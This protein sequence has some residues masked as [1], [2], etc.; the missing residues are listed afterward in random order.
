VTVDGV[1]RKA[2]YPVPDGALIEVLLPPPEPSEVEPE[3]IPLAV[4]YEDEALIAIDKPAGMATHPAPGSRR[5]TLVAALLHHWHLDGEW[6]DPQRPGVVH[7]LDKDTTGVIVVAKTPQAMHALARQFAA[8]T[9][10]K[11]Y[12]AIVVGAPRAA[13]GRIDLAIG[14]DPL[15]RKRMRARVGEKRVAVTS[16]EVLERFGA[17]PAVAASVRLRPETGRTHQIRV[18]LASIGHPLIGDAV[19]GGRRA[20]SRTAGGAARSI[21]EF[22]RQALHAESL[23]LR[24]PADGRWIELVAPLPADMS[25]LVAALRGATS[26][27]T[28]LGVQ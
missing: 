22:P 23:A 19:Y 16:Y 14:R 2:S 3:A 9:V 6:P 11:T 15:D 21:A 7:R 26:I 8:R 28:R 12:Q 13:S 17:H 10:R 18:H 25:D 5:G 27:D 20:T 24:H 1:V 4:L